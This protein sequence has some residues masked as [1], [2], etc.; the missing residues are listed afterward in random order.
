MQKQTNMSQM[1]YSI[2]DK[3]SDDAKTK[4]TSDKT[5][6]IDKFDPINIYRFKFDDNFVN[7]MSIFAKVHQYDD[8]KTFKEEWSKWVECNFDMV[9]KEMRRISNLGYDGDVSSKMYKSARYYFRKKSNVKPEP[10]ER[11]TYITMKPDTLTAMDLHIKSKMHEKDFTPANGY[12]D[13]CVKHIDILKQEIERICANPNVKHED[14]SN[15]IK[16]TYKNRYF[17]ISRTPILIEVCDDIV[18][19]LQQNKPKQLFIC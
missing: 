10:Q 14:I 18:E 12:S 15:K 3:I 16:K 2:V 6:D 11:R 4:T 8:R 13:F 1:N 19:S 7:E 9:N 5:S 17:I